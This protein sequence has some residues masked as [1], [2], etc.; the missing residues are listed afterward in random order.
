MADGFFFPYKTCQNTVQAQEVVFRKVHWLM[1]TRWVKVRHHRLVV[2]KVLFRL[3]NRFLQISA[4]LTNMCRTDVVDSSVTCSFLSSS[5]RASI[6]RDPF[7]DMLAT[8]KKRIANKKWCPPPLHILLVF[9]T[10]LSVTSTA[11]GDTG[12][13]LGSSLSGTRRIVCTSEPRQRWRWRIKD[14]QDLHQAG[15]SLRTTVYRRS[16]HDWNHRTFLRN[17]S[18]ALLPSTGHV[19]NYIYCTT[20]ARAGCKTWIPLVSLH[21]VRSVTSRRQHLIL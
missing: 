5:H 13:S 16:S 1:E 7:Y 12:G 21:P 2:F 15:C 6:S 3:Y 18:V 10:A 14:L 4:G 8:R 11:P 17:V 9:I 19:G 20:N